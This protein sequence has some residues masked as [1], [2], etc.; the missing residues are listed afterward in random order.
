MGSNPVRITAQPTA[1]QGR[2]LRHFCV[3]I[4]FIGAIGII[5]EL[6]EYVGLVFQLFY[7]C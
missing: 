3:R 6:S 1:I 5:R 2:R 4:G 7:I